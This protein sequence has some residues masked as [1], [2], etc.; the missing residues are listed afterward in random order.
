MVV[1]TTSDY[2]QLLQQEYMQQHY[3]TLL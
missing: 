2:I 1:I 3:S